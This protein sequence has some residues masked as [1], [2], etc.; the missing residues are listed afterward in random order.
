MVRSAAKNHR[1]VYIVTDVED[2]DRVIGALER[3]EDERSKAL[4]FELA[5]KAFEHTAHYDAMIAHVFRTRQGG[6]SKTLTL[7][8]EKGYDLRYGENPHQAAAYYTEPF[9]Q[10]GVF[11][12]L[13][14]KTM[15]YN[16]TADL[17]AAIEGVLPLRVPACFAV[18][19]A[20]PC[21]AA[22]GESVSDAYGK[23]Y[24]CDP[25][26]IFGGIVA[27]NAPVDVAAAEKMSEIFLE[28][29]AAPSFDEEAVAILSRKK[30]IRLIEFDA[31]DA[32]GSSGG[33]SGL[34]YRVFQKAR[35]GILYQDADRVL[36]MEEAR[37][38]TKRKPTE[39]ELCDLAFAMKICAGAKSNAI[40]A[41]RNGA[42]VGIGQGQVSRVFAAELAV[43][44]AQALCEREH[45]CDPGLPLQNAVIASD[46]FFPFR[47]AL[48]ACVRAGATAVV[49][50]GGSVADEEIIAYAD[51]MDIAML[52]TGR[53]HFRHGY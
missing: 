33:L 46:A 50:P 36:G 40:V 19:H 43:K 8:F 3:G 14:G 20:M 23:A 4:R 45:S 39:G 24:R 29:V 35:G 30:N 27:F 16:N 49:Q 17:A 10:K 13:H 6:E 48:E 1:D 38:V 32:G 52:F 5:T 22:E 53:R 2:Y 7:T 47:D 26:S 44:N 15:S 41:V 42:T 31:G 25:L 18:K 21:G 12:Q 28:V 11:R 34:A 37:C 51:E 9:S